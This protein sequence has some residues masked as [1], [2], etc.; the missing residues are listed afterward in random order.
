[1]RWCAAAVRR[2][3]FTLIEL[4]VV[5][6]II[7]ILA[8]ILFPVFSRVREKA[9]GT[10]CLSNVKQLVIAFTMYADDHDETLPIW[11]MDW[12]WKTG[13][14]D[15]DGNTWDLVLLPYYRNSEMLYCPSNPFPKTSSDWVGSPPLRGYAMTGYT[16]GS[17]HAGAYPSPE[18]LSEFPAPTRTVLLFEK[19]GAPKGYYADAKAEHFYQMGMQR[20]LK[21]TPEQ[22]G[23]YEWCQ[24]YTDTTWHGKGKNFGFV[25]GHAEFHR[26]RTGPFVEKDTVRAET[27]GYCKDY[28][29]WP[30]P[31]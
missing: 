14:S 2:S 30:E 4:L 31:R 24:S 1:M 22:G 15:K 23:E 13:L 9:R 10:K 8:G 16:A 28:Q 3:G 21:S 11:C 7:A 27:A 6:A 5:I 26:E 18:Y 20:C 12:P 17:D 25:D 19:G 29:D